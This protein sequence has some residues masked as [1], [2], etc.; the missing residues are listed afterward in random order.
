MDL[1]VGFNTTAAYIFGLG[2]FAMFIRALAVKPKYRLYH[3]IDFIICAVTS[4]CYISS[5]AFGKLCVGHRPFYLARYIEWMLTTPLLLTMLCS[6][7]GLTKP[8]IFV[9]VALDEIMIVT[10]LLGQVAKVPYWVWIFYFIGSLAYLPL[11]FF[12]FE[13]FRIE[14]LHNHNLVYKNV[15]Y[16]LAF[17]WTMYPVIWALAQTNTI[18]MSTENTL[19]VVSD[20]FNKMGFMYLIVFLAPAEPL[21]NGS[22]SSVG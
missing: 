9:L 5:I 1:E 6:M 11:V 8:N 22:C 3:Y 17:G 13:D 20:M 2:A 18:A 12:L 4:I 16:W 15:R 14:N 10:G 19:Y 21:I 7:S